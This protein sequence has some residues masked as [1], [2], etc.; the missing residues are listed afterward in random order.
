MTNLPYEFQDLYPVVEVVRCK[1]C[2]DEMDHVERL[3]YDQ[4]ACV[5]CSHAVP[6]NT[7]IIPRMQ[8]DGHHG[9]SIN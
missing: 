3:G 1:E 5:V 2:G 8:N 7:V 9:A 4:Y 6:T